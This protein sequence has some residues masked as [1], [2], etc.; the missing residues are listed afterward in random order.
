MTSRVSA[1]DPEVY[2]VKEVAEMMR[3]STATVYNAIYAGELEAER[4]GTGKNS[5]RI[6][7]RAFEEWRDKHRFKPFVG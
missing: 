5:I 6:D 4:Y 2:F 3:M 1:P 7:R